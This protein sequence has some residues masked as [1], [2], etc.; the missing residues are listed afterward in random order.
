MA[1]GYFGLRE[2]YGNYYGNYQRYTG[3]AVNSAVKKRACAENIGNNPDH[4]HKDI[5]QENYCR[6]EKPGPP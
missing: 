2:E 1:E 5:N 3:L 4:C 6:Q